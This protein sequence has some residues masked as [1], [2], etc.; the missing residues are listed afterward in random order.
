MSPS[1]R[2]SHLGICVTDLARSLRFWCD[3][4][5]FERAE[6]YE[7]DSDQVPGMDQALEV[8]ERVVVTSQFVRTPSLAI[9]LLA[10]TTPPPSGRPSHSRGLV[11]L[12]HLSF[13]VDDLD[14][15]VA[16]LVAC[17]GTV[18]ERTRQSVGVELVF[19]ADPDG[20]RVELLQGI[21]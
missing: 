12:T 21:G 20:V 9:E 5:G 1:Y 4:L 15:A 7:L 16:H 17:G 14:A 2:P 19:L 18:I 13:H 8:D 3:G 6:C 10:Y 11:G